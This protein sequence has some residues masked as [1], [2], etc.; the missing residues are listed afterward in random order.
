MQIS[1]AQHFLDAT[2]SGV[3]HVRLICAPIRSVSADLDPTGTISKS[4]SAVHTYSG[5]RMDESARQSRRALLVRWSSEQ[6]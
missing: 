6:E 1:R 3:L 2:Y 4:V 5:W